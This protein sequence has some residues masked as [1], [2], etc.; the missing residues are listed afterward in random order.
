MTVSMIGIFE[1]KDVGER[2][3]DSGVAAVTT[4]WMM[5]RIATIANEQQSMDR[6]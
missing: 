3:E 5:G 2:S 4:N 6:S 1:E